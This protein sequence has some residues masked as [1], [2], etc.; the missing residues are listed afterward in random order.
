M[1]FTTQTP[2]KTVYETYATVREYIL[3]RIQKN[4][5]SGYDIVQAIKDGKDKDWDAI[6]PIMEMAQP[7][8]NISDADEREKNQQFQQDM[9]KIAYQE[10]LGR[11]L[12][13]KREV[14]QGLLKA[15]TKIYMNFCTKTM[16]QRIE[17]HP[18]F[19]TTIENNPIT[20]LEVI[21]QL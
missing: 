21:K 6:E 3:Q 12:D 1:K 18:D 10:K 7:D 9:N 13:R 15:Y 20:L 4:Y 14:E 5:D 17:E 11:H 16:Q 2:G 19:A 8:S